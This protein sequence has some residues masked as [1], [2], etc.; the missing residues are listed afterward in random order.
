MLETCW[1]FYLFYF[2]SSLLPQLLET[3]KPYMDE[4]LKEPLFAS[5][6]VGSAEGRAGVCFVLMWCMYDEGMERNDKFSE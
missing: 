3:L 4:E 6:A 1:T 2:E 5:V